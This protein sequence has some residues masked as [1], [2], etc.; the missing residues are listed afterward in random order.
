MFPLPM[1]LPPLLYLCSTNMKVGLESIELK[2]DYQISNLFLLMK[3]GRQSC[4]IST[5]CTNLSWILD[6]NNAFL[7]TEL[8]S[9]LS[10]FNPYKS[11]SISMM[12]WNHSNESSEDDDEIPLC[13]FSIL[14]SYHDWIQTEVQF[15]LYCHTIFVIIN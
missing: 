2:N 11:L 9:A 15:L 1:Q 12:H 6:E 7:T 13:V 10:N 8:V 14:S 3:P 5:F 4:E